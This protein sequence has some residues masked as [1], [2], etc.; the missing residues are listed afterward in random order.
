MPEA[1]F[2]EDSDEMLSPGVTRA[3]ELMMKEQ[4][5]R[6]QAEKFANGHASQRS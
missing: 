2:A 1:K 4:H 5:I 3:T 6:A